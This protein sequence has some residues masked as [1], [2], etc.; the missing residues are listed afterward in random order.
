[1]F[2]EEKIVTQK[3]S[4][5]SDPKTRGRQFSDMQGCG[6]IL[7]KENQRDVLQQMNG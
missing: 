4:P 6:S 1:M 2:R 5:S 3:E 7:L